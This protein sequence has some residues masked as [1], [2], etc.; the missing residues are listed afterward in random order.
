MELVRQQGDAEVH[1]V[2][3]MELQC[4][5]QEI[6]AQ[7]AVRRQEQEQREHLNDLYQEYGPASAEQHEEDMA[8]NQ[9]A[10][11]NP[12]DAPLPDG[13]HHDAAPDNPNN[14]NDPLPP[15]N[16]APIP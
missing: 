4:Q 13:A 11:P 8:R 6:E 12:N 14:P 3:E 16:N 7:E 2:Q 1:R 9:P 10:N 15:D 5:Q